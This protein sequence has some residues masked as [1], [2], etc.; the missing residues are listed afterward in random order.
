MSNEVVQNIYQM[1]PV[2][3]HRKSIKALATYQR[4][5][6][7]AQRVIALAVTKQHNAR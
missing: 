5:C 2:P 3:L 4:V 6:N 7:T 1:R